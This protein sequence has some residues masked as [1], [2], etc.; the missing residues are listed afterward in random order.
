MKRFLSVAAL[1]WLLFFSCTSSKEKTPDL[2]CVKQNG[3]WGY[4]NQQGK[5]VI[6]F[7]FDEAG[8]FAQDELA[9]V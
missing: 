7:Q 3:K 1:V 6:P 2:L 9:L 4:V 8:A 5:T